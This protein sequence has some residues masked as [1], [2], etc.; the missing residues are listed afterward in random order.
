MLIR[1]NIFF[2]Y[3]DTEPRR[4]ASMVRTWDDRFRDGDYPTDVTASPILAGYLDAIPDGRALDIATGTGRNAVFL[5]DHGYE[6]DA[7]DASRPGL[8]L[9]RDRANDRE[10]ANR[11]EWIQGDVQTYTFPAATYDLVTISFF[12]CL[13]QLTDIKESIREGGY[14]FV[15]HHV[16]TTRSVRGG[17]SDARFRLGVNE[18]MRSC[19]DLTVIYYDEGHADPTDEHDRATARLLA[20]RSQGTRQSHPQHLTVGNGS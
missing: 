11:I 2:P 15:E 7:L 14:L 6:V 19:L 9:A 5:A 20:R 8:E 18:L 1:P 3:I 17:A 4:V 12:R 16:R 10:V 13:D